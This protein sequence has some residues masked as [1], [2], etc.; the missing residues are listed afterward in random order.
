MYVFGGGSGRILSSLFRG[1]LR[2]DNQ[3]C[4]PNC[5]PGGGGAVA[6]VTLGCCGL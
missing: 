6:I 2:I 1:Y 3:D 4:N 5:N